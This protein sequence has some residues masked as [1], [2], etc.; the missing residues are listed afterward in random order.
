MKHNKF[1][2]ITIAVVACLLST[3]AVA[4]NSNYNN[5]YNNNH[6]D[7][8]D[9]R[10]N[11]NDS[12]YEN[13]DY[14][15]GYSNSPRNV[16][17]QVVSVQRVKNRY[18]AY[19]RQECWNEQSNNYDNNY[20]RDA[21]GSLYRSDSH[22]NIG[23]TVI[24]TLVGGVLG[25]QIGNG[26]GQTIATIGGAILGGIIGNSVTR[27]DGYDRY[28]DNSNTVR[29]CRTVNENNAN[30]HQSNGYNVTYRYGNQTYQS[31]MNKRP[32]NS[33][34]VAVNVQPIY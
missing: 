1:S 11:N 32:G 2:L 15:Y 30:R 18:A 25:N 7:N 29:R 8:N 4:Q 27:N 3:V 23:A 17:A 31:F 26:K 34:R 12:R 20:Y 5:N 6:Y 22:G 21:N 19:Q 10:Y 16:Y 13:N 28:T 14:R 9:D 33:I 24:G